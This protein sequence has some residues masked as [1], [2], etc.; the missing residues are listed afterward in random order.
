M[1]DLEGLAEPT[2]RGSETGS[3]GGRKGWEGGGTVGERMCVQRKGEWEQLESPAL[4]KV[5]DDSPVR[6][7]DLGK[8]GALVPDTRLNPWDEYTQRGSEGRV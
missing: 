5:K 6:P 2:S 8:E 1:R 4:R 3:E 7:H